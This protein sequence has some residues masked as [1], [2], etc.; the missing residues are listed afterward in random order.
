[1]HSPLGCLTNVIILVID[2][3]IMICILISMS[4]FLG[5][6]TPMDKILHTIAIF[7]PC[8]YVEDKNN[9]VCQAYRL[10][11]FSNACCRSFWLLSFHFL[12]IYY[13]RSV[14]VGKSMIII[15]S[16]YVFSLIFPSW[17]ILSSFSSR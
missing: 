9:I 13:S 6:G 5:Q 4:T 7:E 10:L 1:M 14:C 12:I 3:L 16:Y 8:A 15:T 17:R 11:S 2:A